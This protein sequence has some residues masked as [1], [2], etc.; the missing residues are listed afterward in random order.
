MQLASQAGKTE[1]AIWSILHQC[2]IEFGGVNGSKP[3]YSAQVHEPILGIR[4]AVRERYRR[5]K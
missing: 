4:N 2:N 5:V 1:Q 3:G